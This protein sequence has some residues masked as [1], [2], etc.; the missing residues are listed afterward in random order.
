MIKERRSITN[1]NHFADRLRYTRN[2]RGLSQSAL[3]R[4]CGLS[5]SAIA[6]YETKTRQ[7]SKDIF[8]IA[9]ALRV[10]ALWLAQGVGDMEADTHNTTEANTYRLT[11]AAAPH[12]GSIWPFHTVRPEE[13]WALSRDQRMVVEETLASLIRSFQDKPARS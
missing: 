4:A 6:N 9:E 3:A 10:N 5:Q 7:S 12:G 8:A 2:L 11:D 1:V 13:F